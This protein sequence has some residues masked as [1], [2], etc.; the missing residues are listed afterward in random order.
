[1]PSSFLCWVQT[2]QYQPD[3]V[4]IYLMYGV[5]MVIDN[6]YQDAR[7]DRFIIYSVS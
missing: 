5:V 3:F 4:T 7:I 1:M 2:T 6:G